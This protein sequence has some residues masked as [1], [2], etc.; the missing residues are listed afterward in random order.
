MACSMLSES[1]FMRLLMD[2]AVAP[3]CP[4]GAPL[5][6]ALLQTLLQTLLPAFFQTLFQNPC[7]QAAHVLRISFEFPRQLRPELVLKG[8]HLFVCAR[9]E[10]KERRQGSDELIVASPRRQ[11]DEYDVLQVVV[12]GRSPRVAH[13]AALRGRV[14]GDAV[15]LRTGCVHAYPDGADLGK[16]PVG[17]C[18]RHRPSLHGQQTCAVIHRALDEG[19]AEPGVLRLRFDVDDEAERSI[20]VGQLRAK[21]CVEAHRSLAE[22]CAFVCQPKIERRREA[23]RVDGRLVG[24]DLSDA[25]DHG[26][27]WYRSGI[28]QVYASVCTQAGKD[29]KAAACRRYRSA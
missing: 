11:A 15:L 17:L 14:F 16:P 1:V 28:R 26:I 8:T 6:Q 2:S 25:C 20:S 23:F 24:G 13:N 9:F 4:F 10:R 21:D 12:F 29:A 19:V 22:G 7:S 5:L 3:L 27:E 18:R